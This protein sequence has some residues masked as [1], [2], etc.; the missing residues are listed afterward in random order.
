MSSE[1]L[2]ASQKWMSAR[3]EALER[4]RRYIDA[5][6]KRISAIIERQKVA[7]LSFPEYVDN[8]D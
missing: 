6:T 4:K 7:N 5:E 1:I 2:I 3:L 8:D